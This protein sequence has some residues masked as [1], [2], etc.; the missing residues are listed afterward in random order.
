MTSS[1]VNPIT[2]GE[3][4]EE[5]YKVAIEAPSI[6]LVR[7]MIK[8]PVQ[9]KAPIYSPIITFISHW[10]FAYIIDFILMICGQKR[11]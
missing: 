11:M 6:R 4:G 8:T 9:K 5:G 3:W 2:W 10:I 7:P 1:N